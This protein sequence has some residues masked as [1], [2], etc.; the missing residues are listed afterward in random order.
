[1]K[2]ADYEKL[3]E[4]VFLRLTQEREKE[5]SLLSPI[6]QEKVV[7]ILSDVIFTA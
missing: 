4:D 3:N 2:S 5:M 7:E 6:I 1:M